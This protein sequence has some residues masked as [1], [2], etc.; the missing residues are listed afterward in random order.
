MLLQEI[1]RRLVSKRRSVRLRCEGFPAL[2]KVLFL[3][4]RSLPASTT[5]EHNSKEFSVICRTLHETGYILILFRSAVLLFILSVCLSPSPSLSLSR[6]LYMIR[7]CD[8]N[9]CT[10]LCQ[11][12]VS[13]WYI[14]MSNRYNTGL[15]RSSPRLHSYEALQEWK[16][17]KTTIWWPTE[18]TQKSGGACLIKDL[19]W[20]YTVS[21][22]LTLSTKQCCQKEK[23]KRPSHTTH[24][25]RESTRFTAE[26]CSRPLL[27]D[28]YWG[29][30]YPSYWGL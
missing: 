22:V 12:N 4:Q 23:P 26:Q 3:P 14:G 28:D 19:R 20:R 5:T 15:D 29:L 11:L 17:G 7:W 30:Y 27:V 13:P 25:H 10:W 6:P 9:L 21:T 2:A 16:L 24:N 1:E 18:S 8:T